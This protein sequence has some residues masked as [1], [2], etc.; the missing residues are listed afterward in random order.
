MFIISQVVTIDYLRVLY[1]L[2]SQGRCCIHGKHGCIKLRGKFVCFPDIEEAKTLIKHFR[3]EG[4]TSYES[5]E[6]YLL[7]WE[8]V[9]LNRDEQ[10]GMPTSSR[11]MQRVW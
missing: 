9:R 3:T 11:P 10:Q 7:E 6:R 2:Y 1:L 4:Y 8:Y 5:V